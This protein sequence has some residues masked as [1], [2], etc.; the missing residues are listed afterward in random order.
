MMRVEFKHQELES[1]PIVRQVGIEFLER[2]GALGFPTRK[3]GLN[4]HRRLHGRH[5][6]PTES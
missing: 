6:D 4:R 3:R 5:G 2:P 1:Y